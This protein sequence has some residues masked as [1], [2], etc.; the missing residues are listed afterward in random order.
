MGKIEMKRI[1]VL[2]AEDT[3]VGRIGLRNMLLTAKDIQ[4]VGETNSVYAVSRLIK[5]LSPD[6]LLMD[7]RWYDDDS[8]GSIQIR[9]VKR[10]N[11]EVKVIAITAYPNLIADAWKAGADQVVSKNLRLE[12]LLDLVRTVSARNLPS[13]AD[14]KIFYGFSDQ[15]SPR[16]L[17]VLGLLAQGL[18]DKEIST[19]LGIRV[20]TTKNHVKNIL[21]KLN[22]NNR[23]K[24]VVI[25][26]EKGILK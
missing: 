1:T 7:L 5:E 17:E 20:N 23:Q 25:A 4:I 3:D 8:A 2:V 13:P 15:L 21:Q 24:A 26:R 22:A 18:T 10:E 12:E 6:L 11:P 19:A 16:E 14:D 9:E